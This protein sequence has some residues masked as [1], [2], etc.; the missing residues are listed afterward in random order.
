MTLNRRETI[1]K[2]LRI[3]ELVDRYIPSA[4]EKDDDL[5][6][7]LIAGMAEVLEGVRGAMANP[8]NTTQEELRRLAAKASLL[9]DEYGRRKMPATKNAPDAPVEA[10]DE[11]DD[12]EGEGESSADDESLVEA[13]LKKSVKRRLEGR[14]SARAWWNELGY[15]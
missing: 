5:G 9:L 14:M 12:E 4:L 7:G 8:D 10:T 6:A 11:A 2:A 13:D 1:E 3:A 15:K